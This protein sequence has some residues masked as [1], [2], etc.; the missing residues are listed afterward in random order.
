MI[1]KNNLDVILMNK[2]INMKIFNDFFEKQTKI[3]REIA[4]DLERLNRVDESSIARDIS[5]S[6]FLLSNETIKYV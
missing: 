3:W 1:C 4:S 2:N 5:N 6:Y